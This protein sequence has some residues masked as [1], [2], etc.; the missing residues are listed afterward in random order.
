MSDE[1]EHPGEHSRTL[2]CP[3]CGRFSAHSWD[4]GELY[5]QNGFNQYWGGACKAHGSWSEAA[6]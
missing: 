6:A 5:S 3:D 1:C 2:N 4:T